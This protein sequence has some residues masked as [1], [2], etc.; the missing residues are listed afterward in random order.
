MELRKTVASGIDGVVCYD[1]RETV[2]I[3]IELG[4]VEIT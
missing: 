4:E 3:K 1:M 2:V